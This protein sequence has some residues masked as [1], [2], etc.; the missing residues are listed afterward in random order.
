[1]EI[2]RLLN[3]IHKANFVQGSSY[4]RNVLV[5]P[6]PLNQPPANRSLNEPSYRIIDFGRGVGLGV[7]RESHEYIKRAA[8]LELD[9]AREKGLIPY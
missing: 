1:M 5:Q 9:H 7:N 2:G 3:C 8:E 6:G 4:E